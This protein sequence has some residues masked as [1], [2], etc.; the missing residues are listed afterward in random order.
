MWEVC[1]A[2]LV[3]EGGGNLF[4]CWISDFPKLLQWLEGR[5]WEGIRVQVLSVSREA[6]VCSAGAGTEAG[7]VPGVCPMVVC[8]CQPCH[9]L[10]QTA[11]AFE[12]H[13]IIYPS[14]SARAGAV[15][16]LPA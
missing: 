11:Q 13:H 9:L 6:S 10:S 1:K 7:A 15:T 12:E 16:S 14:G 8:P 4:P 5:Q 2:E 3:G